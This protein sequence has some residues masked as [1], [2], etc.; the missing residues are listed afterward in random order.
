MTTPP[1]AEP[2]TNTDDEDRVKAP[3]LSQLY[4][5]LTEGCNLQCRHCWIQ[6]KFQSGAT[7]YP[8]LDFDLFRSIIEQAKP[9]GLS[10]VKL[11]GGEPLIHPAIDQILDHVL[12]QELRL[13]VETNGI[14]LTSELAEKLKACK[15]T[16]VSVSV[17][18]ITPETHEWVRG[19]EG[20]LRQAENGIRT[21]ASAGFKPQVIM[22]VMRRNQHEMEPVVRWA[23]ERGAGSVKFNIVQ[24]TARGEKM[25]EA[26][27]T[28]TIEELV[29]LGRWVETELSQTTKIQL[30]YSHPAAFRPLSRM[31]GDGSGCGICN[32]LNILGVLA[33]A[34]PKT[35][36]S[37][38]CSGRRPVLV[39]VLAI[40]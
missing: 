40:S 37:C 18:G 21:L 1:P 6:P 19:V 2:T 8:S 29:D 27:E 34:H 16:F 38:S 31:L 15:N 11:T 22:T 25:H 3:P 23:E 26:G 32:V 36:F 5:Y 33:S 35:A 9:L 28:L 4:F 10:G 39:L 14:A 17:D 24:P 30:H 7:T 20:C 13:T 12:E